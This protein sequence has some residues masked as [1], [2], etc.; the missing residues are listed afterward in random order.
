[1]MKVDLLAFGQVVIVGLKNTTGQG[2]LERGEAFGR[3]QPTFHGVTTELQSAVPDQCNV[4][5]SR[6]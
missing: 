5:A 1:M 2:D 4:L 3:A 6:G